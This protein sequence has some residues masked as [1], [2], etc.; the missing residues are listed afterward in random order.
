MIEKLDR[1]QSTGVETVHIGV[2][3]IKRETKALC[4]NMSK[5][6][7]MLHSRGI[8]TVQGTH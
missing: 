3:A 6:Q 5:I 4:P 2:C 8:Q 7:D 1:L